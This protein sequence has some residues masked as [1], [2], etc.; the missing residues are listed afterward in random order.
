MPAA[1]KSVKKPVKKVAAARRPVAKAAVR[2]APVKRSTSV[3]TSKVAHSEFSVPHSGAKLQSFKLAKAPSFFSFRVTEQTVYWAILGF[4]V[5]ALG[6]WVITINDKVQY[7]YDQ[8]DQQNADSIL[9]T[10][11]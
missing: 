2:K 10:K 9:S 11:K 1:K 7:L 5:L 4:M 8:I 3:R 6:V